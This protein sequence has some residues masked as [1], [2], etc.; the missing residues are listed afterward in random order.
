MRTSLIAL[1]CILAA[2]AVFSYAADDD[3]APT[4][5]KLAG[6]WAGHR[7]AG[8]MDKPTSGPALTL[9]ITDNDVASDKAGAGTF[10]LDTSKKPYR[11]NGIKGGK[12]T[13]EGIVKVNGKTLIWCVGD[14]GKPRPTTFETKAGQWCMVLDKK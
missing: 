2:V 7:L 10:T 4:V 5:P 13:Y 3:K 12:Q 11:M 8:G 1:S 14:P 9:T 6:V